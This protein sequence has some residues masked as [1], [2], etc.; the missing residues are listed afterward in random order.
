MISDYDR[1][2]L[3]EA[4]REYIY[5][6]VESSKILKEKLTSFEHKLLC[7]K[8][9]DLTYEEVIELTVTE[10][11][12]DFESRFSKFLKYSIA[13]IAGFVGGLGGPPLTMFVLYL[14]RKLTDT[15]ERACWR[16][17]PM[18]TERKICRYECQ[19]NAAKRILNQ[20][21]SEVSKCSTFNNPDKCEK[22]LQGEYIK[23]AK[24][25]NKL[26]IKLNAARAALA[27]KERKQ[28]ASQNENA[29][30]FNFQELYEYIKETEDAPNA[31]KV[32]PARE[33]KLRMLLYLGLW[34]IPIP[35]FNDVVNYYI[36]KYNFGCAKR[37]AL[38]KSMPKEICYNQCAYLSAKYAV[39]FLNSQLSKCDKAKKP[40]KCKNKIY[41]LLQDWKLRETERKI[42]FEASLRRELRKR[43]REENKGDK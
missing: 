6:A 21:R 13:G 42:K 14:Y 36:K 41:S 25:V 17:F 33:K 20:V 16:K 12:R 43:Q 8:I 28:G 39:Q 1:K 31:P 10:S 38:N 27:E 35:F 9:N 2:L 37:C 23:W 26:A 32:N 40:L 30:T 19:L 24:R 15:C 29:L 3:T 11:I 22:K 34:V 18:S 4:G 5:E 7:N